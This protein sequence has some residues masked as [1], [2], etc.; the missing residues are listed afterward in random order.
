MDGVL[1]I[2]EKCEDKS[3]SGIPMILMKDEFKI[4]H[5]AT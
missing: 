4:H 5:K 2:A 1:K 3:K